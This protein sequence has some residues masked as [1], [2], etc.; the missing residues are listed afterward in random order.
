MSVKENVRSKD[1]V[2]SL[3]NYKEKLKKTRNINNKNLKQYKEKLRKTVKKNYL[4]LDYEEMAK[5]VNSSVQKPKNTKENTLKDQ[6]NYN[7]ELMRKNRTK[8]GWCAACLRSNCEKCKAC[9]DRQRNGG[10][11]KLKQKCHRRKCN[12]MQKA[13]EE[14]FLQCIQNSLQTN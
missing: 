7:I 3:K 2:I 14:A 10:N 9:L 4:G 6:K 13:D 5:K 8:C 1:K 12:F 11:F